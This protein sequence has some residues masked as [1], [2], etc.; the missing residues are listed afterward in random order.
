MIPYVTEVESPLVSVEILDLPN[1]NGLL[2]PSGETCGPLV[3]HLDIIPVYNVIV[4][5]CVVR[6]S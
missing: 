6:D 3:H 2:D 1:P 5:G 4:L